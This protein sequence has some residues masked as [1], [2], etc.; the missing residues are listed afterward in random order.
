MSVEHEIHRFAET[1]ARWTRVE[2]IISSVLIQPATE[3]TVTVNSFLGNDVEDNLLKD[4]EG[5]R[6]SLAAPLGQVARMEDGNG[7]PC[8]LAGG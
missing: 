3:A 5:S 7:A 2:T 1:G 8:C 4:R 6:A